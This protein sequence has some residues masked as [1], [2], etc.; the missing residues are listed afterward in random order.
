MRETDV[1]LRKILTG[2]FLLY[3]DS[4]I[5]YKRYA[6]LYFIVGVDAEENEL[7]MLEV[8][9]RFVEALDRYFGNVCELDLIFNFEQA[10]WVLDEMI[11]GSG[12]VVEMGLRAVQRSLEEAELYMQ[13]EK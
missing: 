5:V 1:S 8:I 4:K 3:L 10:F 13:N 7:V 11:G 6:S 2:S 12:E 9:H